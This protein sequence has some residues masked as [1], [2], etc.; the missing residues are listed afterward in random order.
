MKKYLNG[1]DCELKDGMAVIDANFI[2][3]KGLGGHCYV[4]LAVFIRSIQFPLE[5]LYRGCEI[6]Q[7][8]AFIVDLVFEILEI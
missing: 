8:T 7:V 3:A 6:V 1:I 5:I 4:C 2:L